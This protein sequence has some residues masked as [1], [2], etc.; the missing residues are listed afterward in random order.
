M[1]PR[2]T[3][4][5]HDFYLWTQ[6]QAALLDAQQFAAL[7][8]PHLIE[9]VLSLGQSEQRE[10]YHRL[11]RLLEHLLK[12][13]LAARFLPQDLSRA[14]RGWRNTVKAQRLEIVKVLRANP[15]LRPMVPAE[16]ADAYAVARL[17]VDTALPLEEH[18]IPLVCPWTSAQVLDDAF[19]PAR[20]Q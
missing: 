6:E 9:E 15:S 10:L 19:W 11:T 18:A 4:Y 7:D 1:S 2:T 14:G 3:G 16:I 5:A 12:L 17:E 8:I 20:D 13:S